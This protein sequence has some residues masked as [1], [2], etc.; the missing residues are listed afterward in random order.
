MALFGPMGLTQLTRGSV[1][2]MGLATMYPVQFLRD[3]VAMGMDYPDIR[4]EI[5]DSGH[6][7]AV[8]K[9]DP[10]NLR[11]SAFLSEARDK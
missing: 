4:I 9:K 2:M 1:A 11:L 8:E 5:L 6:L 10:V 7:I 3:A